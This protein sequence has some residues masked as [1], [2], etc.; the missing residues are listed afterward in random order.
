MESKESTKMVPQ[1]K[2]SNGWDTKNVSFLHQELAAAMME[3]TFNKNE[4][5]FEQGVPCFQNH[6]GEVRKCWNHKD[7]EEHLFFF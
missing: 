1:N 4:T 5:I 7:Q 6:R 3:M 2:W